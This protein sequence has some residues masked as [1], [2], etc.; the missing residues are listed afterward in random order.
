MVESWKRVRTL[1][2]MARFVCLLRMVAAPRKLGG[3]SLRQHYLDQVQG[4]PAR[5]GLSAVRN[6][7]PGRSEAR[8]RARGRQGGTI[9]ICNDCVRRLRSTRPGLEKRHY[10]KTEQH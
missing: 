7:S 1:S 2:L 5:A 9:R 10:A 4:S 6:G 8:M 3:N